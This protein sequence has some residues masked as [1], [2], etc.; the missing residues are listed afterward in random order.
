MAPTRSQ[1]KH[2]PKGRA[3]LAAAPI[4]T[5]TTID[6]PRECGFKLVVKRIRL[7]ATGPMEPVLCCQRLGCSYREPIGEAASAASPATKEDRAVSTTTT[8]PKTAGATATPVPAGAGRSARN[9]TERVPLAGRK[10]RDPGRGKRL[11]AAAE[12]GAPRSA[13]VQDE[14]RG[15]LEEALD[16]PNDEDAAPS[17]PDVRMIPLDLIA[18]HALNPRK[19]FDEAP[20]QELADSIRELGVQQPIVVR[21]RPAGTYVGGDM[22]TMADSW[23]IVMGERRW[24]AARMAGLTHIPAIVAEVA[25]DADHLRR[26][27]LEN[28]IREDLDPIEEARGYQQLRDRFGMKQAEIGER[29]GRNR[30]T[31]ANAIRLLDLPADVVERISG[32]ELSA[33]HGKALLRYAAFP[34]VMSKLAELAAE[35]GWSSKSLE[36]DL[37]PGV[38]RELAPAV[39]ELSTY[40]AGFDVKACNACPFGAKVKGAGSYSGLDYCLKPEHYRELQRAAKQAAE[41]ERGRLLEKATAKGKGVPDVKDLRYGAYETFEYQS[42]PAGCS[43]AC[44][45]ASVAKGHGG[46]LVPICT[47]PAALQ[48]LKAAATKAANAGKRERHRAEVERMQ[49]LLDA[50]GETSPRL[51]AMLA[52]DVLDRVTSPRLVYTA[53]E[54][55]APSLLVLVKT[56]E[57]YRDWTSSAAMSKLEALRPGELL[58]VVGEAILSQGL[59]DIFEATYAWDGAGKAAKRYLGL[60]KDGRP[61]RPGLAPAAVDAPFVRRLEDVVDVGECGYGDLAYPVTATL[62]CVRCTGP[63]VI[64]SVAEMDELVADLLAAEQRGQVLNLICDDCAERHAAPADRVDDVG[65]E[66]SPAPE[67]ALA[68]VAAPGSDQHV[69][70]MK[71]IAEEGVRA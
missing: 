63:A 43:E 11:L 14:E 50:E 9:G 67:P 22:V 40:S 38:W 58:K 27:L 66:A 13:T 35:R 54:R 12:R 23:W 62:P 6:C 24:R 4:G 64:K 20:L 39:V 47:N 29:I 7:T 36:G 17:A 5:E 34:T 42:R 30:A 70:A 32:G 15:T 19:R 1:R 55:R 65:A 26:A 57:R 21:L 52:A 69:A 33:S 56:S 46:K 45:C 2:E 61:V 41:A 60:D 18:P 59:H 16:T 68:A 25:D 48:R 44:A 51:L 10:P 31:V 3:H 28:L 37:A 49:R 8:G 71:Q 53:A